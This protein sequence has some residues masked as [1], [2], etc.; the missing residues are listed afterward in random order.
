MSQQ[1]RNGRPRVPPNQVITTKFPVMTAGTPDTADTTAWTLT[2][3]GSVEQ[4]VTL[5]WAAF[6]DLPHQYFTVDVHCVT[7]WSKLDTK[8]RGVS[9]A[10]LAALARPAEDAAY[11]QARADGCYTANLRLPD[12]LGDKAFVA[13]EYDGKPLTPEHGG[14]A[15][16]VVPDL[17]FWKSAK[18]LRGLHFSP[19]DYKGYWERLGYHNY[20]DPWREQRYRG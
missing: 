5:G 16:L 17:Y 1:R 10:T 18:W 8:W 20:G 4:T 6:R 12:L 7:R 19:F 2:L 9:I 14:P 15:R 3:D 13:T 11:V